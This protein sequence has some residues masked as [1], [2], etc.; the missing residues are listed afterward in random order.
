M[1]I[2]FKNRRLCYKKVYMLI[3]IFFTMGHPRPM[4]RPLATAA[5]IPLA[6]FING[7]WTD[8]EEARLL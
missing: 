3:C 8:S 2:F 6:R 4:S 5:Y 1:H 7:N